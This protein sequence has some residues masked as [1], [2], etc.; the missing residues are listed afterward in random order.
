MRNRS[1]PFP[2]LKLKFC[3]CRKNF[4]M[5]PAIQNNPLLVTQCS[6]LF[7]LY[8]FLKS[9]LS[10]ALQDSLSWR[11]RIYM[12]APDSVMQVPPIFLFRLIHHHAKGVFGTER[13]V[14]GCRN[15]HPRGVSSYWHSWWP[16][17]RD[18]QGYLCPLWYNT[19][20]WREISWYLTI[21]P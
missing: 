9:S 14:C 5:E 15:W 3:C 19:T 17:H 10:W 16:L 1:L 7:W 2:C 13:R 18:R 11:E 21:F 20:L 12:G 4:E 6:A 8:F